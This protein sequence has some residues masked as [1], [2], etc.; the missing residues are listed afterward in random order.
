K[1]NVSYAYD[2]TLSEINQHSSGSH[3]I[4]L[5]YMLYKPLHKSSVS[6]L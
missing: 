6:F 2:V 5:G 1:I 4:V 3:E